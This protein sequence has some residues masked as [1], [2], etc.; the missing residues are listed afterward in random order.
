M[1][2]QQGSSSRSK[3]RNYEIISPSLLS[4]VKIHPVYRRFSLG[5]DYFLGPDAYVDSEGHLPAVKRSK[6]DGYLPAAQKKK[7][8][9]LKKKRVRSEKENM[10]PSAKSG[11][12][13]TRFE[14]AFASSSAD[15]YMQ[16][17]KGYVPK[18]TNKCTTWA[19]NNFQ[20]WSKHRN[21]RFKDEQCPDDLLTKTP[22][23]PKQLCHWLSRYM[24]E[25]RQTNGAKYPATTLYQLLCGLNR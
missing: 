10:P 20:E 5:M 7:S 4:S 22:Y 16:L 6:C 21:M 24:A 19:L 25:T 11:T 9:T 18:N 15:Q 17:A 13:S 3:S 8:L 1:A 2:V 23:D 12:E 14:E